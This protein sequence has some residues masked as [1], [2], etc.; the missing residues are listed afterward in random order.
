MLL[1]VRTYIEHR[2]GDPRLDVAD[3]AAAH[4]VSI[5]ALQKLFES[6]GQTVTG[7][8]RARRIEHCRKDLAN[9]SLADQ[10][11]SSIAAK[12]GLVDPAHFSRLFKTT[13]G[14]PPRDYRASALGLAAREIAPSADARRGE[15]TGSNCPAAQGALQD[16]T[17]DLVSIE[18][19][20][21]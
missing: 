5:R 19:G 6:D 15:E 20:T 2:L 10:P 16:L 3:I 12:W 11:V 13:Y 21:P 14:L 9:T 4:H 7:W 18:G 1:R 17:S 8:I